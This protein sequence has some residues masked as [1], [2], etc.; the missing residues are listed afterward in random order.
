MSLWAAIKDPAGCKGD[1]R[2]YVPQ[3]IFCA[4][5]QINIF[6]KKKKNGLRKQ[7]WKLSVVMKTHH[8]GKGCSDSSGHKVAAQP[9]RQS[10]GEL[11]GQTTGEITLNGP[12]CEIFK[13]HRGNSNCEEVGGCW[14]FPSPIV[15]F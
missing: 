2:S 11:D 6:K 9:C 12:V 4:A 1:Q 14:L 7:M 5:K 3:L 15:T 8:G 13:K 10:G